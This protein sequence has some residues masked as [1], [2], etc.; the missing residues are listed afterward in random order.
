[1]RYRVCVGGLALALA[2]LSWTP[3]DA[4]DRRPL[5][6]QQRNLAT[7]G[8]AVTPFFEGW[9]PN[10][11]GTYTVSF[12]YFNRNREEVVH[13]PVGAGQLHRTSGVQWDTTYSLL[14]TPG[15]RCLHR[16]HAGGFWGKRRQAGLDDYRSWCD[17]FSPRKDRGKRLCPQS[18]CDGNGLPATDAQVAPGWARA[19]GPDVYLRQSRYGSSGVRGRGPHWKRSESPSQDRVRRHTD[20]ADGLG[21]RS[22]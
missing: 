16:H 17:A 22:V 20:D 21:R 6:A 19:L 9:Y 11:N 3:L 1:M 4:Q 13:V 12:G 5:S 2:V 15:S 10:A 7:H 8:L 18:R 14:A